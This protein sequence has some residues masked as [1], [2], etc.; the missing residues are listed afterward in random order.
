MN[1]IQSKF[2]DLS[3]GDAF[4]YNG[5]L[6]SK[7]SDSEGLNQRLGVFTIYPNEVVTLLPEPKEY[8]PECKAK[9]HPVKFALLWF[10][11]MG[12]IY[13]IGEFCL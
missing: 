4:L 1:Y 12:A 2:S 8:L 6:Y 10:V 9:W 3:C 11:V 13:A 7:V 5:L